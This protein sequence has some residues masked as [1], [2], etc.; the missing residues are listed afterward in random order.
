[1]LLWHVRKDNSGFTLIEMIAVT[2]I[3][4][5]IA[6]IA[7]PN[8]L[9]LLNRN[10]VNQAMGQ[11]EG[12]LK[13]AQKQAIRTGRQCTININADSITNPAGGTGCLLSNRIL[14]NLVTLNSNRTTIVFSGKGNITIDN[15]T[16]N[17]R[18]VLITSMANGTDRQACVVIQSKLG[19]VRTGEY[20]GDP[21]TLGD[22]SSDNCQ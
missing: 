16:G 7:A 4:G 3:T 13:E 20:T 11:V 6:A 21:A 19:S 9:G 5:I 1:M 17:P 10:R 14:N 8:L 15:T 22:D 2:I 12:A 18:P